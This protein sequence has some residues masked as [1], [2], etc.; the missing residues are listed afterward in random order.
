MKKYILNDY[1]LI[2]MVM[3]LGLAEVV[4]FGGVFLGW[5]FSHCRVFFA[6]GVV[7]L[8]V[9]GIGVIVRNYLMQGK[10]R[11]A[12][13]ADVAEQKSAFGLRKGERAGALPFVCMF[14]LLV[15]SQILFI[16]VSGVTFR[17][18]DMTVEMVGSFLE[19][20]GVYRVNPITGNPYTAGIPLRLEI[21][22]LPTLYSMICKLTGLVPV[23]LVL[24][25][26]PVCVLLLS[27]TAFGVLGK[28]LFEGKARERAIFLALVALLMWAGAYMYG[29]DGFN[30]LLCGWRGVTIRNLVLVPRLISLC[31]RKK[32][33]GILLCLA[34]EVC[35]VWTL[36]G[37][38][39]CLVVAVG[40]LLAGK[41]S[42]KHGDI[43]DDGAGKEEAV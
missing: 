19:N 34:A 28:V 31:M 21:L 16:C 36:Y 37:L 3:V 39:V 38:G 41:W 5:A 12:D 8:L 18:G 13:G 20:D 27:Y 33:F 24:K 32:Y 1:I 14:M 11:K 26:V 43:A 6:V 40:M 9:V 25:I 10:L 7:L 22:G 42:D 23:L 2:G 17:N 4:H 30:L 29:M 35:L 15:L